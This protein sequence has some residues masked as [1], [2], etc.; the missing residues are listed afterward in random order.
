MH[1]RDSRHGARRRAQRAPR[2]RR[3]DRGR[4]GVARHSLARALRAPGDQDTGAGIPPAVIE[5]M[6]DPFFTTKRG[7]RRHGARPI[8]RAWDRDRSRR[9]DRRQIRDW[10]RE[11]RFEIWLPVAG[12]VGK[13]AV[14]AARELPRGRG[15]TVMIVDDEPTLVALAEE[16]LAGLGYEPVGFESS[17]A[18][19][20]AFRASPSASMSC[21]PMRRCRISWAPNSRARSGLLRPD[22]PIILMSGY[23]GATARAARSRHRRERG[24][25][26]AAAARRISPSRS[27]VRLRSPAQRG[28]IPKI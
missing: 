5:R 11:R 9:R 24:A 17:R 12:E 16:M 22:I 8:A 13:P 25:A 3:I 19:L 26:Q 27:P 23:G 14:E 6:F 4:I 15:E 18:A 7:R 2:S 28:T 21:S 1:Q 20:Q 10:A